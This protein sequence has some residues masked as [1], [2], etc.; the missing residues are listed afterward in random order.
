[1]ANIILFYGVAGLSL[2][3]NVRSS[4][5]RR[6]VGVE[7]L[8]HHVERGQLRWFSCLVRMPP[9]CLPWLVDRQWMDG[10]TCKELLMNTILPVAAVPP[11]MRLQNF[12]LSTPRTLT[13]HLIRNTTLTLGRASLGLVAWIPQDAGNFPLRF[14]SMLT[15]LHLII[16]GIQ[17]ANLYFYH[18]DSAGFTSGNWGGHRG[19]WTHCHVCKIW[20]WREAH[21]HNKMPS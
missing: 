19:R 17:A 6:V 5:I 21:A 12:T 15:R 7:P 1:M 2:R 9:V 18:K 14:C 8:L 20:P 13:E 10:L 16:N 11:E 3:D 4:D